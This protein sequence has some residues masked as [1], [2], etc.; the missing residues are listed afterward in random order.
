MSSRTVFLLFLGCVAWAFLVT[1]A[2][3]PA[4]PPQEWQVDSR[5]PDL[6]KGHADS[7]VEWWRVDPRRPAPW[8]RSTS[9]PDSDG[10]GVPDDRDKC[11]DT[12]RGDQVDDRGCTLSAREIELLDTGTLSLQDIH[13]ETEK[14]VILPESYPALD[15]VGEILTKWDELRIEIGGHTDSWGDESYN[16][17]LSQRRAQAVLDYLAGKFAIDP[18]QY[19]A[20]GYGESQPVAGNDT[21]DGRARN[22]R[23]EFKVLNRE[24]L[25]RDKP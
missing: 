19:R 2:S 13:F 15:E 8:P 20:R 22:R 21:E 17:D 4:A 25:K 14:A 23:V 12:P 10:D 11:P 9:V 7:H 24:V 5:R 16:Q 3:A 1:A 18:G 6:M